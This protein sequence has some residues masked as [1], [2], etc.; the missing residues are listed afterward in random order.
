[1]LSTIKKYIRRNS[2]NGEE[3]AAAR[4]VSYRKG[5][6]QGSGTRKGPGPSTK[7]SP[8]DGPDS[9]PHRGSFAIGSSEDRQEWAGGA[10]ADVDGYVAFRCR[11]EDEWKKREDELR[12]QMREEMEE[13][14]RKADEQVKAALRMESEMELWDRSLRAREEKV[15]EAVKCAEENSP[16]DGGAPLPPA[17][18]PLS[19][20]K[21]KNARENW[22]LVKAHHWCIRFLCRC[23]GMKMYWQRH[24]MHIFERDAICVLAVE[25]PTA[26]LQYLTD[27]LNQR[28]IGSAFEDTGVLNFLQRRCDEHKGLL[29]AIPKWAGD[30]DPHL[31]RP[32]LER[33]ATA[34]AKEPEAAA[35]LTVHRPALRIM[36]HGLCIASRIE[37]PEPFVFLRSL[38]RRQETGQGGG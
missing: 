38:I 32:E 21:S 25:R 11:Y 1:M 4:P 9:R 19:T 28:H 30:T 33:A 10:G 18:S 22:R 35:Y 37:A 27:L 3:Q 17:K 7:V 26:P 2:V 6:T 20:E 36:S 23:R 5:G 12:R 29:I 14:L 8:A 34:R 31:L 13:Q 24:N 15:P 16:V